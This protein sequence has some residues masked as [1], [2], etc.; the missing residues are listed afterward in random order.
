MGN[1]I[2]DMLKGVAKGR[3]FEF[4][5]H[6][7]ESLNEKKAA[8]YDL[9]KTKVGDS[10][11]KASKK[12]LT[13]GKVQFHSKKDWDYAVNSQGLSVRGGGSGL[14]YAKSPKA[15]TWEAE[16]DDATKSGWMDESM[17]TPG[18]LAAVGDAVS[19]TV[20]KKKAVADAQDQSVEQDDTILNTMLDRMTAE[21]AR[22]C[23][24]CGGE[25]SAEV[26]GDKCADCA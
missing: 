9:E 5:K 21:D 26:K 2:K 16:W 6:V 7:E 10:L 22:K 20:I 11:F 4:M 8:F 13:E 3:S 1:G 19:N 17:E 18:H 12:K 25:M 24:D 14:D 23:E 15:K